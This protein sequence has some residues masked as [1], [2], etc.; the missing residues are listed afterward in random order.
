M[1]GPTSRLSKP[2]IES[3]ASWVREPE[4]AA[5]SEPISL[6]RAERID[7]AHKMTFS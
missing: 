7:V 3:L 6:T 1:H 2:A 4:S 5:S